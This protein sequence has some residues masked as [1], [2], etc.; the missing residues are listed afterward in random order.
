MILIDT[1]VH[2]YPV[3]DPAAVLENGWKNLQQAAHNL[4]GGGGASLVLCLAE[5][6]DCHAFEALSSGTASV[7][8]RL[9]VNVVEN[10]RAL[11]VSGEGNLALRIVAGRQVQTRDRLE[12]LCLTVDAKLEDGL[13]LDETVARVRDAGGVSVL[14]WSPGKWWGSRGEQ[15]R[16]V[17][18]AAEPGDILIGDSSLRPRG[19]P[20][21]P[22]LHQAAARGIGVVAGTDPLPFANQERVAGSYG[23]RIDHSLA[24]KAPASSLA[25]ALTSLRG[26]AEPIGRR[27]SL[28]DVLRCQ[29]ALR[30]GSNR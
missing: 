29:V 16:A 6:S 14:P 8:G 17:V 4:P 11:Q 24:E 3:H 28:F 7:P 22:V 5:R 25:E 23:S 18:D 9:E 27:R 30:R 20:E 12:V 21:D 13:G 26:R 15:V 2:I 1:H 19:W 10:S